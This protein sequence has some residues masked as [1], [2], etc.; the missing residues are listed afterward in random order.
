VAGALAPRWHQAELL[1]QAL[2]SRAR[3]DLLL[4]LLADHRTQGV[5]QAQ[6]LLDDW[7]SEPRNTGM[8]QHFLGRRFPSRS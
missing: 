5:D 7:F 6:E 1:I 3:S 8:A 4:Y 2:I